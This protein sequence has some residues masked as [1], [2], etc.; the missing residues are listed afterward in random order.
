VGSAVLG[1]VVCLV[2]DGRLWSSDVPGLLEIELAEGGRVDGGL[3]VI[4]LPLELGGLP[5]REVGL[6]AV[7]LTVGS[8]LG[9]LLVLSGGP[10]SVVA[11]FSLISGAIDLPS[12]LPVSEG[13]RSERVREGI[14]DIMWLYLNGVC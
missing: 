14:A 1:G 12:L 5:Y 11:F 4:V 13:L 10:G 6:D 7:D 2:I 3:L 8:R 9:D